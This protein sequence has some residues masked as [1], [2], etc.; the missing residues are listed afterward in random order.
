MEKGSNG[1][2]MRIDFK[3]KERFAKAGDRH[4]AADGGVRKERFSG[5]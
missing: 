3:D 2:M 4:F 5:R 1:R